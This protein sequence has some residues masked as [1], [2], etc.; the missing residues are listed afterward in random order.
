M[1]KTLNFE[2]ILSRIE[3]LTITIHECYYEGDNCFEKKDELETLS[4]ELSFHALDMY[5]EKYFN[6]HPYDTSFIYV[7]APYYSPIALTVFNHIK[8]NY[9][10]DLTRWGWWENDNYIDNV[11]KQLEMIATYFQ[12]DN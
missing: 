1:K 5:M 7:Q 9:F 12:K 6:D 10:L 2:K 4:N 11:N 3:E 8:S